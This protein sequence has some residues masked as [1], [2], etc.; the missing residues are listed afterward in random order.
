MNKNRLVLCK[1]DYKSREE[2][3]NA[4]RDAVMLLLDAGYIMTIVY[5]EKEL[6]IVI[7]EY[8]YANLEYGDAYPYWLYPEEE[9]TVVYK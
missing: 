2:F 9:E 4:I 7:I 5:D 3:K 8:N 1:D 6:G